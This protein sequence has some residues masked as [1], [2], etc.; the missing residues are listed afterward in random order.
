M[1]EAEAEVTGRRAAGR[2]AVVAE[3][4]RGAALAAGAEA[5]REGFAEEEEEE[6]VVVGGGAGGC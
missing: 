6:E 5:G 3:D 2:G 1:S 4:G